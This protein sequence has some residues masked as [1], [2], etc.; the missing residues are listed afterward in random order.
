MKFLNNIP[1][2]YKNASIESKQRLLRL[3]VESATYNT[4]TEQLKIKLKPIFQALRIVKDNQKLCFDK[5]T[6]L[7]NLTINEKTD[8]N[9]PVFKNGAEDGIRTH[10]YRNHNPRS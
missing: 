5:V 6:T 2:L 9:E 3:V 10:A 4:E 1:E 7:E 8:L